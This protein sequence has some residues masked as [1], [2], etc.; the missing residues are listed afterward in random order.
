MKE[1]KQLL[2]Y[3]PCHESW[4]AMKPDAGGR[5]CGSCQKTV[6]DFTAM[7]DRELL[8][9][10]AQGRS[11]ICG[12][13]TEEQLNRDLVPAAPPK[14]RVWAVWWQLLIAGLLVS[15]EAS[16]QGKLPKRYV[17]Q[18]NK[19]I[20]RNPLVLGELALRMPDEH[21][22]I[23]D[24]ATEM[25]LPGASVQVDDQSKYFIA[26]STGDVVIPYQRMMRGSVLMVTSIGYA[27]V[28]IRVGDDWKENDMV[29][30]L[31]A[32]PVELEPAAVIAKT[33]TT[34]NV[35][36][37]GAIATVS[38]RRIWLDAIKDTLLCRKG[39]LNL[40]PNP[41]ARGASMTL[42]LRMDKPGNFIAQLCSSGGM[43]V[44]TMRMENVD[45]ARTELMSIPGTLA[46]GIYFVRVINLE[47]GKMY[48]E[49]LVVL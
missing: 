13:M 34:L 35:I 31:T 29:I 44:E 26:D 11:N 39:P 18:S 47:T 43:V 32:Q 12:R 9:W 30:R 46:A 28:V 42:S 23:I 22:R 25:P 21:I 1:K 10:F 38:V 41:V 8:D 33:G 37:G 20:V 24:S 16:S 6:V 17:N 48:T 14:K 7:S 45:K 19:G 27:R 2:I 15:T 36:A 5:Y 49:K 3:N 4:D 40:Y